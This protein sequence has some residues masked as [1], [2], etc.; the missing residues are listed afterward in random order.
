MFSVSCFLERTF[1]MLARA[2]PGLLIFS[3]VSHACGKR[4]RRAGGA[5]AGRLEVGGVPQPPRE[6]AC[7]SPWTGLS[8]G[9]SRAGRTPDL[10]QAR[11]GPE[12]GSGVAG[13]QRRRAGQHRCAPGGRGI[14]GP[15]PFL[16]SALRTCSAHPQDSQQA[17]QVGMGS[18]TLTGLELSP[19]PPPQVKPSSSHTGL[20]WVQH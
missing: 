3:A 9:G 5:E 12:A 15:G 13:G 6:K 11:A 18:V 19:R 2:L 1:R 7:S 14:W 10:G 8:P 17:A 4:T 20:Y 16:T